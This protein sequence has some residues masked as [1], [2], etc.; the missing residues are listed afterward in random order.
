MSCEEKPVQILDRKDKVLWNKV[1]E[2]VTIP[3]R[4]LVS[5]PSFVD[6]P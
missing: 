1:S 6:V 4:A 3:Y 5:V 2:R